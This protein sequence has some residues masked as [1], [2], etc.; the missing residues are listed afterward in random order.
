MNGRKAQIG[1]DRIIHLDWIEKTAN[2]VMAGNTK[3]SIN[4]ILQDMLKH[5]LSGGK[6]GVRGSREKTITILMKIWL[7]V[8]H[9]L[10]EFRDDGLM[11]LQGLPRKNRLAV[12]WGMALAAYPFWG[13][14][15]THTGRLLRLQG[16]AA[17][18]HVQRRLKE[19]YGER[20]TASRA[21][22]RVLRS[23]IDWGVLKETGDKG[24]YGQ[25]E[26]YTI[27]EP[28]LIAWMVEASLRAR[29]NR[30][31]AIK[32]LLDSPSIFPFRLAHLSAEQVLSLSP[33]LDILRHGLDDDLV[34]LR[35]LHE[36]RKGR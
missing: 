14:V 34:M 32:D 1:I 16:T 26:K 22:Q 36:E 18:A 27:E 13:A 28:K 6:A 21:T 17:A 23:F 7:N 30:S 24:V 10:E 29:V 25:G 3:T 8:P 9:E 2:L 35:D 33:R 19:D 11:I 15:A 4:D 5:N 31:A 12:H 20:E